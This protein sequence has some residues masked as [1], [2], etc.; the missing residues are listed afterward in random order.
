VFENRP[1]YDDDYEIIDYRTDISLYKLYA[2]NYLGVKNKLIGKVKGFGENLDKYKKLTLLKYISY[3]IYVFDFIYYSC[4]FIFEN[5][6]PCYY[7]FG[8]ILLATVIYFIIINLWCLHINIT[9]VVLLLDRINIDFEN[10]KSDCIWNILLTLIG[11]ILS[12]YFV[13]IIVLGF[14]KNCDCPKKGNDTNPIDTNEVVI[15]YEQREKHEEPDSKEKIDK[16]FKDNKKKG[17]EPTCLNCL[18]NKAIIVLDP[19]GHKC[20]CETC[21]NVI[22]SRHIKKCPICRQNIVGKI[23][24]ENNP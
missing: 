24:P 16:I 19:C 5:V 10:N 21:F 15:R 7:C 12:I 11:I 9:Y 3:A 1:V 2:I 17:N 13:F 22:N 14:I 4:V 20:I 8:T 6:Q 18:I 23:V